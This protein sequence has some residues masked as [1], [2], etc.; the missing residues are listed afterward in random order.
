MRIELLQTLDNESNRNIPRW[1]DI[2]EEVYRYDRA[3]DRTRERQ[4]FVD[5][6]ATTIGR[7][8]V[9]D[10]HYHNLNQIYI[11]DRTQMHKLTTIWAS[12]ETESVIFMLYS[13][14]DSLAQ[15]VNLAYKFGIDVS[16]VYIHHRK[17]HGMKP[18]VDCVRC[19]LSK[20]NDGLTKYLNAELSLDWFD[21]FR[22]LRN[23]ITHKQLLVSNTNIEVGNP[24]I[25]IEMP[26]D[27]NATRFTIKPKQ[28]IEINAYCVELRK[29]IADVINQTYD[30]LIPKIKNI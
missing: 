6:H 21:L 26:N 3:S 29:N 9:A 10:Y 1:H 24:T 13:A 4:D 28:G 14:L 20:Q 23:R 16:R 11:P 17:D 7:I 15:E 30:T 19:D 27:P 5:A 25:Y 12:A 8:G 22:K 18:Q 2:L